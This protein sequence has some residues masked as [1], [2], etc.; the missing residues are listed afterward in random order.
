MLEPLLFNIYLNDLF[1]FT[2]YTNV[3]NYADDATF[4]ACDSDLKDLEQDWNMTAYWL[5]SGF[6]LTT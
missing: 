4:H 6:T 1:Y 3:C 2:E 5:L